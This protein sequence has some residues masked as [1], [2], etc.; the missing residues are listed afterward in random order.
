MLSC[1]E[2]ENGEQ[3]YQASKYDL[4]MKVR[5]S[6]KSGG[7]VVELGPKEAQIPNVAKVSPSLFK[8]KK[9]LVPVDFSDCSRK[10]L[11]YAVPFAKQ[12]DATLVLLYVVEPCVP[13]PEMTK[14]DRDLIESLRREGG[15][16]ELSKLK[17]TLDNDVKAETVLR[18]G[19]P[20]PEIVRAAKELS[21]DLI[22]LST[23]G[24]TGLVHMFLGSTAEC[25]V[26]HAGCPVVVVREREHEFVP[27]TASKADLALNV[28][29][30]EISHS[31]LP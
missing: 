16:A 15:E 20:Y 14:V 12:F 6:H 10:A 9:I 4:L 7:V 24:H 5:P 23:H 3:T 29:S 13:V 17:Q 11:Q 26:R 21:I 30:T 27:T 19:R 22:L 31:S 8:L 25:V 28:A 2:D 18:V 1:N